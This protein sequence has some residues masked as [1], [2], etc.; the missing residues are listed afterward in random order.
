MSYFTPDPSRRTLILFS[1][2][3]GVPGARVTH[4]VAHLFCFD[5]RCFQGR[6]GYPDIRVILP[7]C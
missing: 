4:A 6:K 1:R 7:E 5:E 3:E 2:R